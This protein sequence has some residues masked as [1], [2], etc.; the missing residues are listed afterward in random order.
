M[1]KEKGLDKDQVDKELDI[2]RNSQAFKCTLS[3]TTR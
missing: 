3:I 1:E 2:L